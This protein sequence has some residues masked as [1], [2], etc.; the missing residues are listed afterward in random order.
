MQHLWTRP[1]LQGESFPGR[2]S[3]D[4][5][6]P[7][8]DAAGEPVARGAEGRAGSAQRGAIRC[9]KP[10]SGSAGDGAKT[11]DAV[12]SARELAIGAAQRLFDGEAGYVARRGLVDHRRDHLTGNVLQAEAALE[13]P[14][15]VLGERLLGVS[16]H[17]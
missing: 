6:R 8:Y 2:V 15:D 3:G 7:R 14:K 12:L 11:R 9:V 4:R 17:S 1:T 10:C 13:A 5:A 16:H